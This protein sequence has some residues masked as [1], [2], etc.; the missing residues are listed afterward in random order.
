MYLTR[1]LLH[2]LGVPTC[3]FVIYTGNANVPELCVVVWWRI[4]ATLVNILREQGNEPNFWG[5]G[6]RRLG[7]LIWYN[8]TF[9]TSA[10]SDQ[11]TH[12]HENGRYNLHADCTI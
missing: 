10:D 11:L 4:I 3:I 12:P 9:A 8:E 1:D 6:V 5:H 7:K 2:L